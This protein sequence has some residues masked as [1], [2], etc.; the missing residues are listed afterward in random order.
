MRLCFPPP[1]EFHLPGRQPQAPQGNSEYRG[2][3]CLI[4]NSP[5]HP[6]Q[7]CPNANREAVLA[8][9]KAQRE[10]AQHVKGRNQA[11][12]LRRLAADS[13]VSDNES[14]EED[15]ESEDESAGAVFSEEG[16]KT[17]MLARNVICKYIPR[18][19]VLICSK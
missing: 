13:S 5:D 3:A 14:E 6:A 12:A 18:N 10:R 11:R 16:N 4:C 15:W 1:L 9:D 2:G 17:Y 19:I 8:Y 7:R